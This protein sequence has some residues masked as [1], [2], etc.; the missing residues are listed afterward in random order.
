[1]SLETRVLAREMVRLELRIRHAMAM[2]DTDQAY[3][4]R[5]MRDEVRERRSELLRQEWARRN[6]KHVA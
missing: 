4:F 2:H 5:K 6:G 1:M 3:A